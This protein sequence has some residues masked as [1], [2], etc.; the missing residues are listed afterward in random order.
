[1]APRPST[2]T[3]AADRAVILLHRTREFL[4]ECRA[5]AEQLQAA[6]GRFLKL[7]RRSASPTAC[8]SLRSSSRSSSS[9]PSAGA[10]S[11]DTSKPAIRGRG[12]TGHRAGAQAERVVA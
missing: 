3:D 12:K 8:W 4:L 1:M 6:S 2:D 7:P 9:G 5:V 10:P 11:V